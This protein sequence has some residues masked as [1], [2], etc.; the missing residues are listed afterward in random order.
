MD[1]SQEFRFNRFWSECFY[2]GIKKS[3]ISGLFLKRR[4]S[5]L[6]HKSKNGYKFEDVGFFKNKFFKHGSWFIYGKC[7]GAISVKKK[8]KVKGKIPA[9]KIISLRCN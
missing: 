6:L 3:K 1:V 2:S 7:M 4:F 8:I 9:V 5:F